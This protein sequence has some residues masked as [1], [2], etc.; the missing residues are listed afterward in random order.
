MRNF[1]IFIFFLT[2]FEIT[3]QRKDLRIAQES[4][5]KSNYEFGLFRFSKIGTQLL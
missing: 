5:L 2:S 3:S 1:L 4:Y